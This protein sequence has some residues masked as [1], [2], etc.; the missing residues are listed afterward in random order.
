MPVIILDKVRTNIITPT[1]ENRLT[2]VVVDAYLVNDQDRNCFI[3]FPIEIL[4]LK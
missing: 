3:I 1:G 2:P 4:R